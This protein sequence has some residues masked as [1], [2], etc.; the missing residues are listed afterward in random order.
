MKELA[1]YLLSYRRPEYILQTIDSILKQKIVSFDLI[2]SENSGNDLVFDV[3]Q[4]YEA[5]GKLQ[6]IRRSPNLPALTHI[7]QCLSEASQNY[8]YF[9]L[10]HDDDLMGAN[11]VHSLY[12]LLQKNPQASAASCNAQLLENEKRTKIFNP[13]LTNLTIVENP[14]QLI[15]RYLTPNL[16]HTPFPAYMYRAVCIKSHHLEEIQGGKH[17]DVS[18]LVQLLS[19]GPFVW[20]PEALIDYRIHAAND[21]ADI[22]LRAVTRLSLFFISQSPTLIPKIFIFLLKNSVKFALIKMGISKKRGSTL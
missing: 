22:D 7:N 1:V 11:C 6:I 16:S 18:F 15:L 17:S 12:T 20:S 9:M 8:R 13:H 19:E 4:K 2:I 3:I 21:S 10:F 14:R 5:D